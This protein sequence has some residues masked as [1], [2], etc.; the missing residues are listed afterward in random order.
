MIRIQ[1]HQK[2]VKF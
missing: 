1:K 2:L